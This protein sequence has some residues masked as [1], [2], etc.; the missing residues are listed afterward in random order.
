MREKDLPKSR[1]RLWLVAVLFG[2]WLSY[3]AQITAQTIN[4]ATQGD[5]AVWASSSTIVGSISVID[6]SAFCLSAPHL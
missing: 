6:A 5:K 3:T 2:C 4:S 1:L